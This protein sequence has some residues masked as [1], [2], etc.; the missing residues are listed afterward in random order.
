MSTK[1]DVY[2]SFESSLVATFVSSV[3]TTSAKKRGRL[4][5]VAK[6]K[7][8]TLEVVGRSASW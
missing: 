8:D 2:K 6:L 4:G 3:A 1:R 7:D 5:T